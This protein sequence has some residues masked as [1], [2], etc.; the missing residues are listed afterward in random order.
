MVVG[1]PGQSDN[2]VAVD[3]D[4]P[5][6]LSDA[7]AFAEV[8]EHGASLLRREMT[9]EQG[10]ALAFGEPAFAGVTVEE[11]D[12]VLLAVAGAN[13]EGAGVALAVER[14]IRVLATEAYEVV[15]R[16]KWP[17]GRS[18]IGVLR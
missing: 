11:P 4:Q 18:R 8:V 16:M 6:D 10:R 9:V 7:A 12:L 3:T 15:H 5:L 1:G 17:G 14:A 13:R 2:G